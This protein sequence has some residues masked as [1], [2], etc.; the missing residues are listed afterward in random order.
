MLE[1]LSERPPPIV[2]RHP[3]VCSCGVTYRGQAIAPAVAPRLQ[4][5]A[6]AHARAHAAFVVASLDA[7]E[8]DVWRL[9][10]MLCRTEPA[11]SQRLE[12]I[13]GGL[14]RK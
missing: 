3:G 6:D 1:H 10:A 4:W 12:E 14:S 11:N 13:V 2:A 8:G 5:L 7:D 9:T